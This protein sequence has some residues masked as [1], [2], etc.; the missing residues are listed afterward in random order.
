MSMNIAELLVHDVI[1]RRVPHIFGIPGSGP[2]LSLIEATRTTKAQFV[3]VDNEATAAMAAGVY[4]ELRGAPAICFGITGPGAANLVGGV[5]NCFLDRMPVLAITSR[6]PDELLNLTIVQRLDQQAMFSPIVKSGFTLNPS[7]ARR[8]LAQAVALAAAERPGPVH[9]DLPKPFADCAVGDMESSTAGASSTPP[10]EGNVVAARKRIAEASSIVLIAGTDALR[11]GAQQEIEAIAESC[12]AAVLS[13]PRARGLFPEDNP[14]YAGVFLGIFAEN[15]WEMDFLG[16]ADLVI[17]AGVDPIEMHKPWPNDIPAV[18]LQTSPALEV[19]CP[20]AEIKLFGPLKDVL[21]ELVCDTVQTGFS[22]DEISKI[23]AKARER[24][25]A[26]SDDR[27]SAEKILDITRRLLPQQGIVI[28]ESAIYN[29]LAEH[30]WPVY[31]PGTYICPGGSRTIGSVM[32]HA[33]GASLARPK[34]PVIGICGDGGFL[35]RIQELEVVARMGLQSVF[36]IINDG[37]L[38]TIRSRQISLGFPRYGLSL[39][40]V[41]FPR[42]AMAFGLR[43]VTVER[44]QDYE[45][46]LQTALSAETSTVIDVRVEPEPYWEMFAGLLGGTLNR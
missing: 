1:S 2:G 4:G 15:M 33:I 23:K 34:V 14:R 44:S 43:G 6:H 38:G 46:E 12:H 19:P 24:F 35:M 20:Q 16:K 25:A 26:S 28:L 32:P 27:F 11:A 8:T 10:M 18:Q 31:S 39:A 9:L 3:L 37:G 42:I 5:A 22:H 17:L 40:P 29:L 30:V 36:V 21:A 45:Q 7:S 13:A 41:D